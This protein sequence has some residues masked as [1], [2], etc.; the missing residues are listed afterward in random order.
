MKRNLSWVEKY[1]PK[2][3][4][5]TSQEEVIESLKKSIKTK[6][7]PHLIFWSSWLW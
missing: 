2:K 1:R 7:I 5:V 6:N 4:E 3:K